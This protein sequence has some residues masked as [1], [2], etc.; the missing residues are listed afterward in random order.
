VGG[1]ESVESGPLRYH[2]PFF[3]NKEEHDEEESPSLNSL[4]GVSELVYS[5]DSCPPRQH[6][7]LLDDIQEHD[8]EEPS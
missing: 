7:P 2:S 8:E 5:N 1:S 4:V 3:D 6:P